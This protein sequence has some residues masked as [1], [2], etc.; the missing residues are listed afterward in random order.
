MSSLVI[1]IAQPATRDL[2][3]QAN[4]ETHIQLIKQASLLGSDLVLFPEL[5]LTGYVLPK[6]KHLAM[7]QDDAVLGKLSSVAQTQDIDII[8]GCPLQVQGEKPAIGAAYLSKHGHVLHYHK[9]YLH[10]GESEWCCSGDNDFMFEIKGIKIA[11]AICA[12]FCH[13]QHATD[14]MNLGAQLYLVSALISPAGYEGDASILSDI[15]KSHQVPVV[16]SNHAGET[17]GWQCAG[18]SAFWNAQGVQVTAADSDRQG[19]LIVRFDGQAVNTMPIGDE[20]TVTS[21]QIG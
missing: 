5:S 9:Q 18:K 14:A 8:V 12:D 19:L 3:I 13:A 16:L 2:D 4:T 21:T 15:A 11:L 17:G 10:Q 6:L 20:N 1:A 7:A